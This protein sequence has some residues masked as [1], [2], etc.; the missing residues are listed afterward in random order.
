MAWP[1]S[2]YEVPHRDCF[3]LNV[4][5]DLPQESI[6]DAISMMSD[7]ILILCHFFHHPKLVSTAK[8]INFINGS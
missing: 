4:L 2:K 7:T 8:E 3:A 5:P 1:L 6:F